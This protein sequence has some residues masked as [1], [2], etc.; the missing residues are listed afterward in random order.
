M[1]IY[2]QR[3]T[4]GQVIAATG[5]T[6]ASLQ[7][8]IRRGVIVGQKEGQIDM[9]GSPGIRRT[10]T[11]F[12]VME[13]AIAKAL[14]DGGMDVTGAFQAGAMFAHSG[15]ESRQPA[16]PF[17]GNVYTLLCST[18]G[19]TA[20]EAWKPGEDVFAIIRDRLLRPVTF[21]IVIVDD[22]FDRVCAALKLHPEEVKDQAYGDAS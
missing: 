4:T 9:P 16:M 15:D 3:F 18:G 21:S 8:W 1:S 10:F 12:N 11:F 19:S 13:I 7:S 6:N 22:V 2:Q 17:P 14:T 5:T 20:I